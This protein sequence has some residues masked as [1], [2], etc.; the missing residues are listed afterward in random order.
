ML[1]MS[2]RDYPACSYNLPNRALLID[3]MQG[4]NRMSPVRRRK[5]PNR[6]SAGWGTAST[7][8]LASTMPDAGQ[9]M[10]PAP[11]AVTVTRSCT[12]VFKSS[13]HTLTT[14]SG[15][16]SPEASSRRL[17]HTQSPHTVVTTRSTTPKHPKTKLHSPSARRHKKPSLSPC[18]PV[19]TAR[20]SPKLPRHRAH[21]T[22][23]ARVRFCPIVHP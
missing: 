10:H 9:G 13:K 1:W 12:E 6:L 23:D 15:P 21:K 16:A 8:K 5:V 3:A 11:P 22:L 18:T 20:V 2:Y 19:S 14:T 7:F 4:T 17:L